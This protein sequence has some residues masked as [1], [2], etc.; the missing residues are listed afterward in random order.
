LTS[1]VLAVSLIFTPSPIQPRQENPWQKSPPIAIAA[2]SEATTSPSFLPPTEP[3]W[4]GSSDVAIAKPVVSE[5]PPPV[6]DIPPP[7][8]PK[9]DGELVDEIFGWPGRQLVKCESAW[10][11]FAVGPVG[12][13]GLFQVHPL[14][15]PTIERMGYSWDAMFEAEP[16][17]RVAAE[18]RR[19]QGLTAWT[20]YRGIR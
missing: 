1:L 14:W 6:P 3:S 8:P 9:T 15:R 2:A 12:E 10:N 7:A 19:I 20:C 11:R 13:R 16:N 18:I 17:I 4:E 5:P